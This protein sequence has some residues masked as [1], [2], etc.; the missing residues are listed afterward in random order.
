MQVAVFCDFCSAECYDPIK[1]YGKILYQWVYIYEH[2]YSIGSC[3]RKTVERYDPQINKWS[4][5]QEEYCPSNPCTTL[6]GKV[7]V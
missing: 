2:L 5:R 7:V 6:H 4:L 1:M 3:A